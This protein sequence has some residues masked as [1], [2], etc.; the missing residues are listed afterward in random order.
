[1][2]IK[3]LFKKFV[4]HG[5]VIYTIGSVTLLIVS[6]LFTK[7]AE[8]QIDSYSF[9]CFA[10]FSY[11]LSLGSTLYASD[12]FPHA[13]STLIHALCYNLGFFAFIYMILPDTEFAFAIIFTAIFAIFYA[14][15]FIV[16][17]IIRK[18]TLKAGNS[19]RKKTNKP[20]EKKSDTKKQNDD[21]YKKRFS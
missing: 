6:R 2:K 13:I 9:L 10:L 20:S 8:S 17:A 3:A 15:A 4:I 11:I 16:S 19:L 7:N 1:M 18:R 12:T 5:A 14:I 21:T